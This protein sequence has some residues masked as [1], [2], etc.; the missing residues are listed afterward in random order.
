MLITPSLHGMSDLSLLTVTLT[1][2]G[3]SVGNALNGIFFSQTINII[4]KTWEV[5]NDKN[6]HLVVLPAVLTFEMMLLFHEQLD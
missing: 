2:I 3:T 1:F 4:E 6:A 5:I